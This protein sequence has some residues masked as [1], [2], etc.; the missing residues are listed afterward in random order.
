MIK[1][2]SPNAP[3]KGFTLM[4]V[5]VVIAIIL[6]LAAIAVPAMQAFQ[7]KANKV[8][9]LRRMKDLAATSLTYISDNNGDL[10]M[11][12]SKGTDSWNAA[13]DPDNARAWLDALMKPT[14]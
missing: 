4:E 11:E 12:D 5:L 14:A 9:T 8:E 3:R 6:V 1:T 7:T 10:P 13:A 2:I